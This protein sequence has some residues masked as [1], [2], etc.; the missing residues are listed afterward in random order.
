MR[1]VP[2]PY[3]TGPGAGRFPA[4]DVLADLA[5]VSDADA[6]DRVARILA[7]YAAL[8]HWLLRTGGAPPGLIGHARDAARAHLAALPALPALPAAPGG[9]AADWVEGALLLRLLE[10]APSGCGPL[11]RRAAAEAERHGFPAGG[12]AL[13]RAARAAEAADG[14][15]PEVPPAPTCGG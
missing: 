6:P 11:L 12:A 5:A 4:D 8:R 1:D 14:M 7:R 15:G 9:G 2:P 3:G 10:P 13:R